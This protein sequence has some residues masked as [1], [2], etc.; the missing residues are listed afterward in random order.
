MVLNHL[1]F[2]QNQRVEGEPGIQLNIPAQQ[3]VRRNDHVS[4]S[5]ITHGLAPLV[6][7]PVGNGSLD[8]GS[9]LL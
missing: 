3:R 2:I 1:G 6:Q 5:G 4:A 7:V 8:P 9:E